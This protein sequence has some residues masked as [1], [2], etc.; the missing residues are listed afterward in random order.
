MIGK[1]REFTPQIIIFSCNWGSFAGTDFSEIGGFKFP[2]SVRVVKVMCANKAD[3][4]IILEMLREGADGVMLLGCHPGD[5]RYQISNNETMGNIELIEKLLDLTGLERKRVSLGWVSSDEEAKFGE[6]ISDFVERV[7]KM[8]PNRAVKDGGLN[9]RLAAAVDAASSPRS[10]GCVSKKRELVESGNIYSETFT[11]RQFDLVLDPII[12]QEYKRARVALLT[13][14]GARVRDV[15][16]ALGIEDSEVMIH[17]TALRQ[18]GKI[19]LD[20]IEDDGNPIFRSVV[21]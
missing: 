10:R 5:C 21:A 11:E 1:K 15:A 6:L 14:D 16:N 12:A 7:K 17:I 20:R 13:K 3:P 9:E 19:V 8:G 2:K 18:K 4:M